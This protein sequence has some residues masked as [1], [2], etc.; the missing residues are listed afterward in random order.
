MSFNKSQEIFHKEL[1]ALKEGDYI[2]RDHYETTLKAYDRY[3]DDQK[4]KEVERAIIAS[5]VVKDQPKKER[6]KKHSEWMEAMPKKKLSPEELRERNIS[7][8]LNLGVIMLLI[9]GIYI[10]TSNW[11]SMSN[12]MKS[13]SIA[14]ISGLFYAIAMF[15]HLILKI[16]KTSVAFFVLGSLFLPI[17]IL[18]IAWFKLMGPYFSFY[19]EGR[20]ILGA[21]GSLVLVPIYYLFANKLNSRLFTWI[22][23]ITLTF[24]AGYFLAIFKVEHDSFYLGMTI[25]SILLVAFYHRVKKSM[26]FTLFIKELKY[27]VPIQ[28]TLTTVLM[29]VFFDSP[30]LNSINLLVAA[31]VF[32]ALVYVT[33]KK[34]FHFAF[35]L[36]IVYGAYQ[37]IQHSFMQSIG[38]IMYVIVGIGF[39]AVPQM[40]KEEAY[41]VKVFRMT[42]AA[43]SCLAFI[44]ISLMNLLPT[45]TVP[46][47]SLLCAFLLVAGQFFYLTY[48]MKSQ[49]FAYFTPIFLAFF[50]YE[51]I[52]IIDQ[53][54][55]FTDLYLPIFMIGLVIHLVF[56]FSLKQQIFHSIVSSS[57]DVGLVIMLLTIST[58]LSFFEH[59]QSGVMFLMLS[60]IFVALYLVDKRRFYKKS[61]PWL[62]PLFLG[63]AFLMVGEEMNANWLFYNENLGLTISIM[64]GSAVLLLFYY[65]CRKYA[66]LDIS[67][68]VFFVAQ[69]F[70]SLAVITSLLL[71]VHLAVRPLTFIMGSI[72]YAGLYSM[73]KRKWIPYLSAAV[74]LLGYLFTLNAFHVQLLIP[75]YFTK[76][77]YPLG[78][79]LLFIVAYSF[80][81]KD[82][83]FSKSYAIAGH[84]FLPIALLITLLNEGNLSLFSFICAI[85]VYWLSAKYV[86]A[87]IYIKLFVYG[88]FLSGFMFFATIIDYFFYGNYNHYAFLI[89]SILVFVNWCYGG[90]IE[91]NRNALFLIPWSLAGV[92][93]FLYQYPFRL[94]EWIPTLGY[95]LGLTVFLHWRNKIILGAIPLL[96]ILFSTHY[97]L[98][99]NWVSAEISYLFIVLMAASLAVAGSFLL[100]SLYGF[101][102]KRFS[103]DIYTVFSFLFLL[104]LYAYQTDD[105]W[106]KIVP[107]SLITLL[108]WLQR[109]RVKSNVVWIPSISAGIYLLQPYYAWIYEMNIPNLMEREAYMLPLVG[110]ILFSRFIL[111]GKFKTNLT[112]LEWGVLSIV[113]LS[114]I[115]D[116]LA[117]NTVYDALILGTLTL[118]SMLAGVYYRLKSYFFVGAVVLLLNV[119]LQARP[120]WGNLP[121]WTYLLIGGSILIAV[122]SYYEWNKQKSA[123]GEESP[124]VKIKKQMKTKFKEWQ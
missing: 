69:G 1:S 120:Y 31:F 9:G 111:Q 45:V 12:I 2:S 119:L 118:V 27:F 7:W 89:I 88:S 65:I 99:A 116:A 63:L 82:E 14:L 84:L 98:F 106:S 24:F 11:S 49:L 43:V 18:S 79:F 87:E 54:F 75:E 112:Y 115:Q 102:N 41:W 60:G 42:S 56:G 68:Q 62:I 80:F 44:Y 6:T 83:A 100:K 64:M 108:F 33:D 19:G 59:F 86:K 10:A 15:A 103:L 96:L 5:Q 32:L 114:F 26:N 92:I 23:Y 55:R 90:E 29:L 28:L 93:A 107:G 78:S 16:K 20:Y 67:K 34:E 105:M 53:F 66:F 72:V 61:A 73:T 38:P 4:V 8:L 121:W 81:N 22:T 37:L 110:V 109:K 117:S 51:I 3:M 36:L 124:L 104:S 122:A 77:M 17:F 123:K 94:L 21:A 40:M 113:S 70:Y 101:D 85:F 74:F 47:Y 91:K 58:S 50:L 97:Y 13:G 30:I 46:S 48:K 76:I 57:R 39:L 52:L 35:T 25:F 71:S 95:A